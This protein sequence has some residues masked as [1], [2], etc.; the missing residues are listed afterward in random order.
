MNN[1]KHIVIVGQS[2]SGKSSIFRVLSDIKPQSSGSSFD[3]DK[4]DFQIQGNTYTL[5]DLPGIYSLNPDNDVERITYDYLINKPVDLVVNVVDASQISRS[6]ELT[7]ELVEL[8]MPMVIALNMLD[9]AQRQ[10]TTINHERLSDILNIPVVPINA[11]LGKGAK[12]LAIEINYTLRN[13]TKTPKLLEYTHHL[14]VDIK[15]LQDSIG[16]PD[17]TLNPC[18]R[19]FAI[20]SIENPDAVPEEMMSGLNGQR[21]EIE[22]NLFEAHKKDGFESVS[23]ERH[24]YAMKL[25]HEIVTIRKS[26]KISF[27]DKVDMLLLGPITGYFFLVSFFLVYFF[28]IFIIGDFLSGLISGPL[29]AIPQFYEPLKSSPFIWQT[30]NG[31]Y[32]GVEGI[33]GIV[34]PYFLPLV[35]LTS[36]FEETGYLNRVAF[37]VDGL[38]HRIG[39]HGK[40]VVPFVLGFGCSVPAIYAT[41]MIE[42]KKDRLISSILIPFVPCSA[43]I[44]VIFALSA[45]FLNAFYAAAVFGIVL[46]VI[47]FS[48]KVMSR[49]MKQP[50]G[51]ILDIP[52][53]KMPELS[54]S[55]SK[56]WSKIKDF[57]KEAFTFLLAGSIILSWIEFFNVAVYINVVFAPVLDF[58][59]GLPEELGSTLLFGFFRKELIIVM[60]NQAMGVP[61]L[62]ELPMSPGQIFTFIVFVTLYFPCFTTFVVLIK[63]FGSK[64]GIYSALLSMAL[65]VIV[66]FIIKISIFGI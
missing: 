12:S 15:K 7:V 40:S 1:K 13:H 9:E 36:L 48:G 37:L 21:D 28:S 65:A 17:V 29:A 61:S 50:T 18:A 59:L 20:K 51:L 24:H 30:I 23:Y 43:R 58:V 4:T 5:I 47:G 52:R 62:S 31:A 38:F 34:L 26:R 6:L 19:F 14:E 64:T 22:Q 45:A 35:F 42:N 11:R 16:K 8:G 27:R 25:S 63:E 54:S 56:T 10:G 44:A 46:L 32:L 3:L 57:T 66:S 2:N 33:L 39:L 53:L 49:F 41:R 55:I 60:A